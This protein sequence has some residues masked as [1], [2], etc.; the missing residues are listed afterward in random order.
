[1]LR[2]D[3]YCELVS[4]KPLII[5]PS[6]DTNCLN[7]N[8]L[9]TLETLY[10]DNLDWHLCTTIDGFF[11][12]NV[13]LKSIFLRNFNI[14]NVISVKELFSECTNLKYIDICPNTKVS[15]YTNMFKG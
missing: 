10:I 13:N 3:S 15:L 12:Y 9:E 6:Y 8:Y 1:M 2:Y 7:L 4:E 5:N 14:D 11:K